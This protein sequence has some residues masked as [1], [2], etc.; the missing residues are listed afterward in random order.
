[1][2]P[3]QEGYDSAVSGSLLSSNPYMY[4]YE[5]ENVSK[6]MA[7]NKGWER[8]YEDKMLREIQTCT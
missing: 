3:Y 2:N 7:W 6:A 1:M 8:G 5:F 4:M